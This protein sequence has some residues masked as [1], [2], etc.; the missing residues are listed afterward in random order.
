M[1]MKY[2]D[3]N[4]DEDDFWFFNCIYRQQT[5]NMYFKNLNTY[6]KIFLSKVYFPLAPTYQPVKI[7]DRFAYI[8][9]ELSVELLMG[10]W[11]LRFV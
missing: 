3:D 2:F 6:N 4:S 8:Q 10:G 11:S 7:H 5:G 9:E 1:T